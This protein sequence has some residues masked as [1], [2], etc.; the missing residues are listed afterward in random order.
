MIYKWFNP[1]MKYAEYG[2]KTEQDRE[3]VL[4][5][6]PVLGKPLPPLEHWVTPTLVQ[7]L[8]GRKKLKKVTDCVQGSKHFINQKAADALSDIWDKHAT[9]YPVILEDKPNEPYYM[10]V[11]HTVIDC[12]DR[13]KSVGT[14]NE[15]EDD[16]TYGYF[17]HIDQWVFRE[18]EI[19]ENVLFV[20]PD[21]PSTIYTT[22]TFK[23]RIIDAGL[24]GFGLVRE[25]W[26][27]VPFIS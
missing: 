7:Y 17:I 26:D 1:S 6:S 5:E 21:D 22:E 20:L 19:K 11:V 2:G 12:I 14:V 13:E 25:H 3:C 18:E 9:L 4:W 23:Q 24:S 15:F 27:E 8:N 10:V 16:E